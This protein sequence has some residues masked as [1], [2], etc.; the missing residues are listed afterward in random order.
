MRGPRAAAITVVM[1]GA[2]FVF[3][4][5]CG[6]DDGA[7]PGASAPPAAD[8]KADTDCGTGGKCKDVG[9]GKR[10]C[11]YTK[12]CT[13]APGADATCGGQASDE[14]ASGAQDCCE[15]KSVPG[16]TYN[17]YNHSQYPATVSS[18]IMDV[19]EVTAGRFR[20]WV[21]ETKGDLR[22]SA[23]AP[24]AGAHPKIPNSGWRPEWNTLLPATRLAVDKMLGP[25]ADLEGCQV[26]GNLDDFGAL[27]WWTETLDRK[28][29]GHNG[30]KTRTLEENTQAALDQKPLNC[31]PWYV[32][33]AFCVWDGGRLPTDAEWGFAASGGS[34]Q[35]PFPWAIPF[36]TNQLVNINGD[37]RL[38]LEPTFAA[39]SKLVTAAL[40]DGGQN[41]LVQYKFT[42]GGKEA[43]KFDN[44]L[45]IA[46]AGRRPQ[47]NGKWGHADLAGGV[48]EW[49]LDRGPAQP[50]PCTD[51]ADVAWP[52]PAGADPDATA[53][54]IDDFKKIDGKD[55]LRWYRGGARV[56]RGGAW[57][58]VLGMANSQPE[59]E[60]T[61]Y[62][63]YP[64]GR[65]Y[66]S[67]G[68]RC[69]RDF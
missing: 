52:S 38:S 66:R 63:N 55:D 10:V 68:G 44:A 69:V 43:G 11:L 7:R 64:V 50:K 59:L 1:G 32:L 39:G 24:G 21:D 41:S 3:A 20:A 36:A 34:E 12:S 40:F 9:S 23:P 60:I 51:C 48:Y 25:T 2:L 22:S 37:D 15:A 33:F 45:H 46:P 18:F 13:G 53:S 47:G 14:R 19:F 31:V 28:V 65:T 62:T 30:G 16:G 67:L 17:R 35:R 58:N 54:L 29:K 61:E 57:D 27:T 49:T 6:G 5:S 56:V 26:G 8:C 42:W 4:P